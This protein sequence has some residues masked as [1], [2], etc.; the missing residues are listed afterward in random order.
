MGQGGRITIVNATRYDMTGS[1]SSSYQMNTW[2]FPQLIAAGKA[3]SVYIEWDQ[4]ILTEEVDDSGEQDY[5]FNGYTFRIKASARNG[6]NLSV[7]LLNF[8]AQ[9]VRENERIDLGWKHDGNVVFIMSGEPG[10]FFCTGLTGAWMHNNLGLLG[11]RPLKHLCIPGSHD[12]GMGIYGNH[13]RLGFECATVTQT[14][15]I[16]GQ[17]VAGARYFDV[18]PVISG[19]EYY[20]GHYGHIIRDSTWQGA[21]GQSIDSIIDDV[22]L[23]SASNPELIILDLSHDL[24]TDLGNNSYR[25]FTQQEW[26]NLFNKLAKLNNLFISVGDDENLSERTLNHYIGNNRACVIVRVR[27]GEGITLGKY[28]HRGFYPESVLKIYDSYSDTN[29]LGTMLSDTDT[30]GQIYKMHTERAN[31][32]ASYFLLSWTLTQSA[33]QAAACGTPAA[34]SILELAEVANSNIWQLFDFITARCYPNIIYMDNIS[35]PN[36]ATVAM[37]V[38]ILSANNN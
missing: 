6:F 28:S 13:T 16:Y 32:D 38:N 9:R 4:G 27:A 22:N 14:Q 26:D 37:V 11:D 29:D 33:K 18:R 10:Q 31:P 20:T 8:S 1:H 36:V 2:Q 25:S 7:Y 21:N 34:K 17:L 12:A 15:M 35:G 3:R 30:R 24:N 5:T 19:G 23:F